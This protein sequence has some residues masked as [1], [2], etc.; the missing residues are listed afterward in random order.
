MIV[1][2]EVL[3]FATA[4]LLR[5]R[6]VLALPTLYIGKAAT[7]ALMSSFPW[8]LVGQ[9]D[10]VWGTFVDPGG[11]ACLIWGVGLAVW[12]LIL[13]WI[14]TAMVMREMPRVPAA[15]PSADG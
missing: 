7:F 14:Q 13:S 4:P 11:W 10:G 9:L 6:G 15:A 3:L 1:A 8:L 5:T 2:R 12:S